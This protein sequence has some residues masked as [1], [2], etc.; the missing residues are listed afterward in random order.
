MIPSKK[1]IDLVV[2]RLDNNYASKK[3]TAAE[4][5]YHRKTCVHVTSN[6]TPDLGY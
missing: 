6:T 2:R 1:I 3:Y 4:R 5:C